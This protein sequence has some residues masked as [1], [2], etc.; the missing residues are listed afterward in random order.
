[1]ANSRDFVRSATYLRR[2]FAAAD[3]LC[4][5][6][7]FLGKVRHFDGAESRFESFVA[8]LQ[9]R[10]IDSLLQRIAGKHAKHHRNACVHLR[11]LQ[12]ARGFGAN[13][14][15]MRGFAAQDASDGDDRI[16]TAGLR[17]FLRGQRQFERTR[18]VYD[19]HIFIRCATALQRV[20]C[21]LQEALGDEA[22]EAA[23]H[24]AE[25]QTPPRSARHRFWSV[26]VFSVMG[27]LI[28]PEIAPRAFPGTPSF[29][30]ACLPW[31]NTNQRAWLPETVLLPTAFR[32]RAQSLP[33]SISPPAAP[34]R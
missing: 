30:H 3:W 6:A 34:F 20:Q 8:A 25:A 23:D 22:V 18:H 21:T 13:V 28:F 26:S 24:H 5:A 9:A 15:V 19:V 16:V 32:R 31:R 29:L 2:P 10:A 1:M 27:A 4:C 33:C 12:P 17:Q 7:Q 14:I 11:Q